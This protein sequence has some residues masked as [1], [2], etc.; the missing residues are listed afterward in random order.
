MNMKS[1][2]YLLLLCIFAVFTSFTSKPTEEDC[3]CKIYVP[4]AFSPNEDGVNDIF[5]PY[6]GCPV[7]EY[8]FRVFNRWG[9]LVYE[10]QNQEDGWNG[11]FKGQP[12][13]ASVYVY[14]VKV[15][16]DDEGE[17]KDEIKTGDVA[18]VR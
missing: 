13:E 7:S 17:L 9:H 10:S 3:A 12:A 4:N 14:I 11:E 8:D 1:N 18:L 2:I 15:T 6:I 16:Y 5:Q